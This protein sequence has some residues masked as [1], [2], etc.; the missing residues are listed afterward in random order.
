LIFFLAWDIIQIKV[1]GGLHMRTH[2][3]TYDEIVRMRL[4]RALAL[5]FPPENR[6]YYQSWYWELFKDLD[7]LE[8]QEACSIVKCDAF[9]EQNDH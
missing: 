9:A 5:L 4:A 7:D 3:R 1:L 2:V 8:F 6:A